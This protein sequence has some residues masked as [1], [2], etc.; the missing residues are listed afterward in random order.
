MHNSEVK[1]FLLAFILNVI[2]IN[3]KKMKSASDKSVE[4]DRNA[5]PKVQKRATEA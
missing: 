3:R 1:A 5:K 2:M 4:Y